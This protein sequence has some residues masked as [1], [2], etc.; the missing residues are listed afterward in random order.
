MPDPIRPQARDMT[1]RDGEPL[2]GLFIDCENQSYVR[3]RGI[4]AAA[5]AE[6]RL[7]VRRAYADWY[8]KSNDDWRDVCIDNAVHQVQAQAFSRYKNAADMALAVDVMELFFTGRIDSACIA[9]GDSDFTPLVRKLREYGVRVLGIG[10][11]ASVSEAFRSACD[12]YVD[13]GTSA[14]DVT[15]TAPSDADAS[16]AGA[17]GP[18]AP[19][20]A[21]GGSVLPKWTDLVFTALANSRTE[22]GWTHLGWTGGFIR[23]IRPD[24]DQVR[25][26]YRTLREMIASRPDLFEIQDRRYGSDTAPDPHIRA[27]QDAEP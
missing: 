14:S 7:V 21:E 24:F 9:S 10:A 4:I 25:Y 2:V 22:D 26:G 19:E 13:L 12:R 1:H 18:R 16:R 11:G 6:G 23:K 27:K 5:S 3:L 17:T 8:D 15:D 20:G